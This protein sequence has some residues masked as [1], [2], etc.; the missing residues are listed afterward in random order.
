MIIRILIL[1]LLI[2]TSCTDG[3]PKIN[4]P[5][6]EKKE[7]K[8]V[9]E[10]YELIKPTSKI[11]SV[12]ILFG[13]FPESARDIRREF[14]IEEI[15]IK[16]GI[17]VMLMNFNRKLWLEENDKNWL[18][19]TL[20][21]S[22]NSNSISTKNIFIGGFSSGGNVS[23]LIANHLIKINSLVKPKGVFVVDSPVDLLE[24]YLCS[25]RNVKRNFSETSVVESKRTISSFDEYFG[26]PEDNIDRY[27][28]F[29]PFIYSQ[30]WIEN[31][32]FLKNLRV[33][34]YTEPDTKWW[35]ENRMNEYE[36]LNAFYLK[37]MAQ[38]L[39]EEFGHSNV[40][41]IETK[42]KGKR[43]NGFRHPHSWSIVNKENLV[44]W[45]LKD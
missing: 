19:R 26:N 28:L 9:N 42:N 20:E 25:K 45:I 17:A 33:R 1:N 43:A 15:A 39:N 13:G 38:Q 32:K 8:I 7:S 41:L 14:Q 40:E 11:N 44:N 23:L 37:K 35:K 31:L 16:N 24:L 10:N 29:S 36:D 18:A 21:E 3:N 27:K 4:D 12:L 30:N 6:I 2:L 34:I 22:I 5:S